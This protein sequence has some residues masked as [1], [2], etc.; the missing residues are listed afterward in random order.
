[1]AALN[2]T[3][4]FRMRGVLR[5]AGVA[6]PDFALVDEATLARDSLGAEVERLVLPVVV[7]PVDSMG[8]RGVVRADD[9]DQA[10]GYARSAVAYSRSRRVIVEELIDGPEFSIDALA[11]GDTIQITGFADRHIV[12]PPYFIEIGH[13][14]P[15]A[16][17]DGDQ[18]AIIAEFERAVR[19]LGIGPG[20]AK[21]DMK[22]SSRGPV[23]GEIAARLSGG[24]M[25]G[26]TYPLATGVNL[27]EA[28]IRIALGEPPGALR[29]RWNRTSAERAVVSI[30]GVIERV[31]GVDSARAVAGVEELFLLRGPG[32]SIRF[33]QN[34]VE[35]VANVIAVADS[36]DAATD[37][38]MR[39]VSAIDVVLSPGMPA[40]DQFLFGVK[41]DTI[42][43]AYAPRTQARDGS[44]TSLIAWS[45]AVTAPPADYRFRLPVR[46]Q[47]FDALDGSP[48][49]SGRSL[50]STIDT[51]R[52]SGMLLLRES[53][54]D[55]SLE[56]LLVQA[57]SR[58]G[59]QGARYALRSLY[60]T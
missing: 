38:A 4:K 28:A 25:S 31:D 19:A 20:A 11:Y 21:G 46:A 32:D 29:P 44:A 8:A 5:A 60:R 59:L 18:A 26:W 45:H 51:L 50:A 10:I 40:T 17:S 23:V 57:I 34:N 15:T 30:P 6:V 35:K 9:W 36:R 12:F 47:C 55:P 37:A 49:W 16:L 48:D 14:L 43:Y 3:D 2:A 24:Y 13:T 42:P 22:L 52:R 58:G 1:E 53:T 56:R 27:S 41:P 39:A 54:A 7:K 33:P